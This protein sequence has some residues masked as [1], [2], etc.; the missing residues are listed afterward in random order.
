MTRGTPEPMG[1]GLGET[2]E[3]YSACPLPW[4]QEWKYADHIC[5]RAPRPSRSK[6]KRPRE[7]ALSI[8]QLVF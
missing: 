7:I 1:R 5:D 8:F 3:V 2:C 6:R 4:N